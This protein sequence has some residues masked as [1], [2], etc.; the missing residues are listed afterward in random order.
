MPLCLIDMLIDPPTLF[1][2]LEVWQR[3]LEECRRLPRDTLLRSQLIA[4]A[5]AHIEAE[6]RR[7]LH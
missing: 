4:D 5:E 3:H 6:R 2:T 7:A 1:D